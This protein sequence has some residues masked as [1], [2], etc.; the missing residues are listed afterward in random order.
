MALVGKLL[1]EPGA[2]PVAAW[3]VHELGKNGKSW[4]CF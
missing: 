4:Q 2:R 1:E 3:R